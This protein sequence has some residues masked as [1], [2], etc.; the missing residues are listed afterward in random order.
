MDTATLNAKMAETKAALEKIWGED[1]RLEFQVH[2]RPKTYKADGAY[3]GETM[4]WKYEV[5]AS[6][7]IDGPGA[8]KEKAEEERLRIEAQNRAAEA[9]LL[10]EKKE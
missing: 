2:E 8:K 7:W 10:A 1:G 9:K 5:A 4:V 6:V 3:V